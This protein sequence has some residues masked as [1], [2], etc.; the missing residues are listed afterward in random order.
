[1]RGPTTSMMLAGVTLALS[2]CQSTE[3]A[4]P[5]L[6]VRD[7]ERVEGQFAPVAVPPLDVPAVP[8]Q[9]DGT[10][11]QRLATLG[12]D[13]RAAHERFLAAEPAAARLASAASG[14]AVGSDAWASAQ[15]ALSDLESIRSETAIALADL[16]ILAIAA[17]V[18]AEESGAI[19]AA[20]AEVLARVTA[21]DRTLESLRARVR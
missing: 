19:D 21:E 16:D 9:I 13:A 14:A 11:E 7:V 8:T 2:A 12:E 17:T 4:Y 15:V 10:M 6:A 1:M 5:S 18:Q 20:R 3:G